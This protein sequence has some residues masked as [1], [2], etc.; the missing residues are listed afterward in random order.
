MKN[1]ILIIGSTGKLGSKLLNFCHKKSI[2]IDAIICK[3]NIKKLLVQKEKYNVRKYFCISN[4]EHINGFNIYIRTIPLKII[5][6]LDYGSNSLKTLDLILKNQKFSYIAIANKEM[7]IAGSSLLIKKIKQSQNYFIP[8]DSEHF[9]LLNSNLKNDLIDKVYIT[10][11]GGPFYFNKNIDLNSVSKKEVLSHP[12]WKMGSN[13]LIDS[14]NFINKLLEIYELSSI[15]DININKINFV[16]SREAFI[17]SVILYKDSTITLN[18]F[19]ND[20]LIPLVKPLSLCF[21][22]H[23]KIN[24]NKIYSKKFFDLRQ[25]FDKRFK[26]FKYFNK[27]ILLPHSE[28][29]KFM[30]LN[31]KAQ[32]LYLEDNLQYNMI[33]DYIISKLDFKKKGIKLNTFHKITNYI[34]S[35][36]SSL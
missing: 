19:N 7:L 2:R 5:Y 13:N 25:K 29:I 35:L 1:N 16:I 14:S 28:K 3:K 32:K 31:N 9:S 18:C 6:F 11:S 8:L 22:V 17:H 23:H 12:K 21:D 27:L 26:I 30:I 33:L 20:M 4:S 15:F 34:Y 10:A 36:E 24:I